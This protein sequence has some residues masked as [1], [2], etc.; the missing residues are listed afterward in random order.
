[1]ELDRHRT[2]VPISR[3]RQSL[4]GISAAFPGVVAAVGSLLVAYVVMEMWKASLRTPWTL[5][6]D[7]SWS[8]L[9]YMKTTLEQAWPLHNPLLG[10][11]F[12][13]DLQ[14]YPLGDT[15]QILLTKP[16]GISRGTQ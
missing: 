6:G 3:K 13:Q 12:G 9:L 8:V 11:P 10:A 7:D 16:L 15:V 1:M 4:S 5:G 14:D 2:Y